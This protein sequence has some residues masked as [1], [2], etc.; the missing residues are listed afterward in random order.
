MIQ[1]TWGARGLGAW[2]LRLQALSSDRLQENKHPT[3][4]TL[5]LFLLLSMSSM[6]WG[7]YLFSI[8]LCWLLPRKTNNKITLQMLSSRM[9]QLEAG[10]THVLM[11]DGVMQPTNFIPHSTDSKCNIWQICS[12]FSKG[13]NII[14]FFYVF[15]NVVKRFWKYF[16]RFEI[17]IKKLTKN[18]ILLLDYRFDPCNLE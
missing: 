3:I 6:V 9:W 14:L 1:S 13:W 5:L 11:D 8:T 12:N 15:L 10:V 16:L 17:K 18:I 4:P 2:P 7:V